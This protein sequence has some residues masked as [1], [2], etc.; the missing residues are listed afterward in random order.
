MN[1]IKIARKLGCS[2]S[3]V[4]MTLKGLRNPDTELGNKI[5]NEAAEIFVENCKQNYI[6][7]IKKIYR[8]RMSIQKMKAEHKKVFENRKLKKL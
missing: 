1:N 3:L 7:H 4:V 8:L 6:E 5:V 2:N